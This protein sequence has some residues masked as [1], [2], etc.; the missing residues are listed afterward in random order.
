MLNDKCLLKEAFTAYGLK[1]DFEL[2]GI[3]MNN[4]VF[5]YFLGEV[6]GNFQVLVGKE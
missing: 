1:F 3:S 6:S 2:I 5:Q 4:L